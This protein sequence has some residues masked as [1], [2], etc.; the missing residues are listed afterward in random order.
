MGSITISAVPAGQ[1][2]TF[3]N[4]SVSGQVISTDS[5]LNLL[6][7]TL[8]NEVKATNPGNANTQLSVVQSVLSG[9]LHSTLTRTWVG[10]SNLRQSYFEGQV[11]IVG[12]IFNGN[13]LRGNWN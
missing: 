2:V 10:Y 9:K 5:S 6:R 12:N 11:E 7:C 3:K 13:G 1:S 8:G 4:L